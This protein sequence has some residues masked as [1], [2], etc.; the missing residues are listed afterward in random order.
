MMNYTVRFNWANA[1][2][3]SFD[4]SAINEAE[5]KVKAFSAFKEGC[6]IYVGQN[7]KSSLSMG[8][9]SVDIKLA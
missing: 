5:A 8:W 4:V 3:G 1:Y 7:L 9:L 6:P 2:E